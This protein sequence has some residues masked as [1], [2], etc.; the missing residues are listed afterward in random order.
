[1]ERHRESLGEQQ[2]F[3]G[4]LASSVLAWPCVRGG[5]KVHTHGP[6]GLGAQ[7]GELTLR[8]LLGGIESLANGL[9][10]IDE[11]P[12]QLTRRAVAF[13]DKL[14]VGNGSAEPI[15]A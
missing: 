14:P 11:D 5:M 3:S 15:T 12:L 9:V 13:L 1:M 7:G 6:L 10:R 2:L 8:L 4:L